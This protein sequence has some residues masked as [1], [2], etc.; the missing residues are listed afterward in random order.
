MDKMKHA[1]ERIAKRYAEIK[2]KVLMMEREDAEILLKWAEAE[3][4]CAATLGPCEI[5]LV[6]KYD[7]M[8]TDEILLHRP[9]PWLDDNRGY[10]HGI[11][12]TAGLLPGELSIMLR[13]MMSNAADKETRFRLGPNVRDYE[14]ETDR[15]R[16]M[17]NDVLC[18]AHA[19]KEKRA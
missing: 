12:V 4:D 11:E 19:L 6:K 2:V 17:M 14:I 8:S 1:F 13:C 3:R 7:V 18:E 15:I 16:G 9:G 10:L 5:M